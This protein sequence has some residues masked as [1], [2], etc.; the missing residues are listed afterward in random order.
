MALP[1]INAPTYEMKLAS[2]GNTIKYRPFLVKEEKILL[3]AL[4]SEDEK[5]ILN[6]IKQI[7]TNCTF[8]EVDPEELPM[9][10]ID[11]IFL[12]LRE[13]SVGEQAEFALKCTSEGCDGVQNIMIDLRQIQ[14]EPANEE[15]RTIPLT[16]SIGIIMKYPNIALVE[17]LSKIQLNSPDA[18]YEAIISSIEA[19]FDG[20]QV[21]SAKEQSREELIQFLD[22]LTQTQFGLIK[23]FFEKIPRL[24]YDIDYECKKCETKHHRTLE[25]IVNFLA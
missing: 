18:M 7:I 24:K 25:G 10:D 4:Q 19:I 3:L 1:M 17:K 22:S 16:S 20:E 21:F 14:L 12:R 5:Q 13:V 15:K 6:A 2:N 23:D 8:G 11:N 9:F